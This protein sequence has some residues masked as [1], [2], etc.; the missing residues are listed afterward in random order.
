M[1]VGNREFRNEPECIIKLFLPFTGKPDHNVKT[2]G[3][4]RNSL[5]D[6][7]QAILKEC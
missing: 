6:Y 4:I 3:N 2:E 1:E 5:P 7:L